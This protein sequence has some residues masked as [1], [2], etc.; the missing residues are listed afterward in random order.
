VLYSPE[1]ILGPFIVIINGIVSR[2]N[3]E[4]S[5][6]VLPN[7]IRCLVSISGRNVWFIH[8][9]LHL[10]KFDSHLNYILQ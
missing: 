2:I 5:S 6:E 8:V 7:M 4:S 10:S 9:T 3:E 1:Q